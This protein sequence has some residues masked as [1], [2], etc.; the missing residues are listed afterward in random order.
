LKLI[1]GYGPAGPGSQPANSWDDLPLGRFDRWRL[2][3]LYR[4]ARRFRF[5][6]EAVSFLYT[7]GYGLF[8]TCFLSMGKS[9]A[10]RGLI[11]APEDI[12]Y[13]YFEEVEKLVQ[14]GQSAARQHDVVSARK[15]EMAASRD[16]LLP[17]IIYGDQ[18]PPLETAGVAAERLV[19]IATSPGYYRGPV[20]V[21]Q[22]VAEHGQVESGDV[23]VI[24]YSDVSWT[25]LFSKAG[26]VVAESGGILS[27]SSIVAREHK[28]PAVVS[29]NGA[30]QLLRN[31][32]LVLVDGYKGEVFIAD[33]EES[34]AS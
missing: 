9:F 22:S 34:V 3:W 10:E 25:P 1:A 14:D 8:R 33:D 20:R 21:I 15:A 19:G 7:Y 16:A 6:R 5:Y 18:A 11:R 23:L 29:V 12:F 13:L 27:H 26:A 24:P 28:L 4:R 17:D 32:T 2:G 31:G 30:C